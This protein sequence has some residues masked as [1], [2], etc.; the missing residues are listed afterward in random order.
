MNVGCSFQ[1]PCV[2]DVSAAPKLSKM[3]H[4]KAEPN[5]PCHIDT[6]RHR[7]IEHECNQHSEP[8]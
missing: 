1:A 8:F 2:T 6:P 5:G 7:F 4:C 3:D